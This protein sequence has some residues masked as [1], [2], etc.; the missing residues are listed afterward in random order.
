MVWYPPSWAPQLPE[1]PD[2]ISLEE[3]LS[4]DQYGRHPL[5]QSR[6]PYTCG[7]TGKTYTPAEVIRRTGLM[8]RA[9]G[10]R[11][12]FTPNED[13]E[14][15]RV[16]TL[17]SVNTIDYMP[18]MSAIH[19]LNGIVTPASAAYSA[20]ELEHQIRS[21][22]SRALFTCVPLLDVALK[23]AKAAGIPEEAIFILPVPGA[24][25]KTPYPTID[26]LVA[27]G[28][29]LP[30]VERLKWIKGQAARQVAFLCYSSG[31]SGLPKAVMLSH[32]NVI[33]NIVQG[34]LH[35]D[36]GRKRSNVTTQAAL[37]LLPLSHIYGLTVN[38]L[39]SQYR[40]DE[41]VILPKFDLTTLLSAI[42][43]FKLQQLNLVPPI[44]IQLVS[45]KETNKYDLSSVRFVFSGAAPLGIELTEDILKKFPTWKVGQGYGM[46][47]AS[48]LVTMTSENDVVPGSSG[49][50]IPGTRAKI[51]DA[52]GNE[53]KSYNQRG[54]LFVQ[55]PS[56]VLGYLNNAKANAE[57]FVHHEDGRWLRTGDEVLV[58]KSPSGH[59]NWFVVDRIKELIK[60]KG[61]QVA[62]AELE[63][64]LLGHS[65]VDDCAV[66]SVPDDRAG[67]AP[68]AFVVRSPSA[69]S[70]KSDD[71]V[72]AELR[73]FV[74]EHK[75]RH[76]WLKGGIEFVDAVP[77]SPSGKI[78]R[79]LLRDREKEARRAKGSKL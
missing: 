69:T 74:E 20:P 12:R 38:G 50:L 49:T 48:P 43:R 58:Q 13:T 61:H 8:A 70:G 68:K 15:D 30:E 3:F 16:V 35:D 4:N 54:E 47:E 59:E 37:G 5:A 1:L 10:K 21:S 17:F 72:A 19:R 51:I 25:N 23:A 42:Q 40:G 29:K 52:D 22:S 53:V 18:F 66:I 67:E 71:Q 76:K 24:T 60:V 45:A 11:L 46:T 32:L 55:S 77:K 78:L 57:T 63:A 36:P 73:K 62:P 6:N 7:I 33:A 65:F 2:S 39:M 56:V 64:H 31:T 27:E 75:A 26:D 41:C 9:I 28:E 14:W 79:R 44:L 34:S